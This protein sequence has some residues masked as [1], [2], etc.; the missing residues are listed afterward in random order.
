MGVIDYGWNR[1]NLYCDWV[2]LVNGDY[3]RWI[4][5]GCRVR[6]NYVIRIWGYGLGVWCGCIE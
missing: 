5:W 4:G 1:D 3:V 2:M 6:C